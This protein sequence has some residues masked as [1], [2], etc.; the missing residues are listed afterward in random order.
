MMEKISAVA[1]K[2]TELR[3]DATTPAWA[4][5]LIHCVNYLV[6]AVKHYNILNERMMRLDDVSEVRKTVIEGLQVEN[7]HLKNELK[8]VKQATDNN[9]QKS[10]SMCLLIHGVEETQGEDTD[11]LCLDVIGKKIGVPISLDDIE[12]YLDD[13]VLVLKGI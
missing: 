1:E 6:D 9:E 4:K 12:N 13:I 11:K 8:A 2:L 3:L 5:I 7:Q 10:R